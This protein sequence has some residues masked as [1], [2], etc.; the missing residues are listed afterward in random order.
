MMGI[1]A[2]FLVVGFILFFNDLMFDLKKRYKTVP[3]VE[4]Y[5]P[6]VKYT[7]LPDSTVKI[8][9]IYYLKKK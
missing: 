8:D 3:K 4:S 1:S 2:L 5:I 9:T 6:K 7:L